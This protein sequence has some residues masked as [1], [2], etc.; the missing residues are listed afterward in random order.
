MCQHFRDSSM[1]LGTLNTREK[2]GLSFSR[3]CRMHLWW[4]SSNCFCD[5]GHDPGMLCTRC[6]ILKDSN[7]CVRFEVFTGVMKIRVCG[8]VKTCKLVYRYQCFQEDCCL[9]LQSTLK[10]PLIFSIVNLMRTSNCT[11]YPA[12]QKFKWPLHPH[13]LQPYNQ[14]LFKSM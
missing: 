2:N 7:L 5:Q 3:G 13:I 10:C 11:F 6:Y 9:H 14:T 12:V 8:D 4:N 1:K